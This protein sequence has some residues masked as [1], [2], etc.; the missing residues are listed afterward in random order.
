MNPPVGTDRHGRHFVLNETDIG[1]L[2]VMLKAKH[3]PTKLR[4]GYLHSCLFRSSTPPGETA[5]GPHFV[6]WDEVKHCDDGDRLRLPSEDATLPPPSDKA[7]LQFIRVV[8]ALVA[9]RESL[10]WTIPAS[11]REAAVYADQTPN[12]SMVGEML[13]EFESSWKTL[14]MRIPGACGPHSPE[15]EPPAW[16]VEGGMRAHAQRKNRSWLFALR[17]SGARGSRTLAPDLDKSDDVF[18]ASGWLLNF[19][20][21]PELQSELSKTNVGGEA[22]LYFDDAGLLHSVPKGGVPPPAPPPPPSPRALHD[23]NAL[24]P[25]SPRSASSPFAIGQHVEVRG[26]VGRPELNGLV[27]EVR[28]PGLKGGR[29]PVRLLVQDKEVG[30][31]PDNLSRTD[32]SPHEGKVVNGQVMLYGEW[33]LMERFVGLL[34]DKSNGFAK[35][36]KRSQADVLAGRTPD[37]KDLEDVVASMQVVD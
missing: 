5:L 33:F 18:N 4:L 10:D 29:L 1:T 31:K 14:I 34:Q 8:D 36:K 23:E 12:T 30:I 17:G 28:K 20:R 7:L 11:Q 26:L 16:W 3:I 9:A 32:K 15:G 2:D 25:P 13:A 24:P 21:M 37:P 22:E 27:G 19:Y 6:D 35:L